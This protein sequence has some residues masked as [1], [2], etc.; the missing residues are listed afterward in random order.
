MISRIQPFWLNPGPGHHHSLDY[1][2]EPFN[3]PMAVQ[4]WLAQGFP[5]K[6]TGD[7]Y[8]MRNE[9]P[10][11]TSV[12]VS[13]FNKEG[14]KDIGLCFY[15]MTTGTFLPPHIDSYKR[16]I[17][18]FNLQGKEHTIQRAIIFLEDWKSGH[19]FELDKEPFMQY[20]AGEVAG[21][22]YGVEHSAGNFGLEPRY[23]L[24]VTG[25]IDDIK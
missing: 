16:Y 11:W 21:W 9:M 23:T 8:D 22:G 2:N 20:Q 13:F 19:Y 25:H 1:V 10:D 3:D 6:F 14:W 12:I 24:Q 17:E 4:Q 15:R 7:M 5:N 18:L